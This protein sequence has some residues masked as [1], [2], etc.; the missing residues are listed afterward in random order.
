MPTLRNF[1][2]KHDLKFIPFRTN[3]GGS[4]LENVNHI[5]YKRM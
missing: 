4:F 2:Q 5:D 1:R 3:Y